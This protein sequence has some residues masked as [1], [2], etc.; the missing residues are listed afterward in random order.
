MLAVPGLVS[1]VCA[2]APPNHRSSQYRLEQE[3]KANFSSSPACD[4]GGRKGGWPHLQ[5]HPASA[6]FHVV[7]SWVLCRNLCESRVELNVLDAGETDALQMVDV[8]IWLY[9]KLQKLASAASIIKAASLFIR[10]INMENILPLCC[11]KQQ[12]KQTFSRLKMNI[13][14][15]IP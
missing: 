5:S 7:P 3:K 4:G 9:L 10:A 11:H 12:K 6:A 15:S 2:A 1:S 8:L 13:V 14:L